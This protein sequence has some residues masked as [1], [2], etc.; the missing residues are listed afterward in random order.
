MRCGGAEVVRH[1]Y[2][3]VRDRDWNTIPARITGETIQVS[4]TGFEI[5]FEAEHRSGEIH[6]ASRGVIRGQ[7]DRIEA[8]MEGEARS[9]FLKNRIGFCLLHAAS[10]CAG[11]PCV[12]VHSDGSEQRSSFPELIA[13]DQPFPDVRRISH[14]VAPG[15]T[16]AVS[17][18]GDVFETEDQRNWTDDS[19]K[20][21]STPLALPFPARIER[22]ARVWQRVVIELSGAG[23]GPEPSDA[24]PVVTI[25]SERRA[26]PRIGLGANRETLGPRA[27]SAL[28]RLGLNHLRIDVHLVSPDWRLAL[29]DAIA[30]AEAIGAE[31]EIAAHMQPGAAAELRAVQAAAASAR[32]ARW[33]VYDSARPATSPA[34]VLAVK[35]LLA[36]PIA[37][38]TNAN[39]AEL[40]RNRECVAAADALA[41]SA[42]PQVH[43]DDESTM[44]ETLGGQAA[45]VRSAI[46]FGVGRPVAVTPITLKPRFNAV[47]TSP[48]AGGEPPADPRQASPFVA[49]WTLGSIAALAGAGAGSITYFECA[50]A[51]GVVDDDGEP[52]PVFR[53]FEA[54]AAFAPDG[55]LESWS[56]QPLRVACLV[57]TRGPA[58]RILLSNLIRRAVEVEVRGVRVSLEPYEVRWL[59]R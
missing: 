8:E 3:A 28:R 45:A 54:I 41:F 20:T 34:T 58:R 19:Y 25:G 43:G 2:M 52:Y 40:N 33:I 18:E 35:L 38:G 9:T 24:M 51:R 32:V 12:I 37:A 13:P 6:F 26:F 15:L 5:T 44:V 46:A 55:V 11:R 57:L 36:A 31:L 53:V 56:S 22:G 39:F 48:E 17:F 49:S 47:A 7:A 1:L 30:N 27:A 23:A 29:T 14:Q 10:E 42:N 21:Y 4:E 16:A 50:G 59:D